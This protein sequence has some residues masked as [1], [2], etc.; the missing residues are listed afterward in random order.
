L[1]GEPIRLFKVAMDPSVYTPVPSF[2]ASG[3]AAPSP[4]EQTLRSGYIGQ[5]PRVDEFEAAL[6]DTFALPR[7]PV[8]VNSGTSALELALALIGVGPGDAVITTPQTCTATNS[9]IVT[10]GAI[11]VWAD[12]NARGL[13][14][15][16][17]VLRAWMLAKDRGLNVKAVMVV[18]WAGARP[19]IGRMRRQ[20]PDDLPIIED[21]AHRLPSGSVADYAAWSFQAIKFLTTGDGG[22]L[23][24]PAS[25][26]KRA[27]LLRWYGLDRD[28]AQDFRC[29]QNIAEVGHK[30]HMN[31]IAATI[32]LA[33]LR[34]AT[35]NLTAHRANASYLAKRLRREFDP[36]SHY[37]FFPY[38]HERRDALSAHLAA[39][40]IET[41]QV[42]ARND[43]HSGF[44]QFPVRLP[45][46][47]RFDATQLALP[48][49]W[50]L[51]RGDLDTIVEAIDAF[52][53]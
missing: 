50:W 37:W 16:E 49:G 9:P 33:N 32:G 7:L 24:T 5:G 42:H 46:V 51:D 25:Q 36:D 52:E 8:T 47:D 23:L 1:P 12:V 13:L 28:G 11:P 34:L 19:D 18:S 17:S 20:L 53:R 41:S 4:I 21:A 39:C 43:K 14:T 40:G 15:A 48:C 38:A 35:A 31:D 3:P 45:G 10:R 29:S 26:V 27:R 22:A 44:Q 6:K 30:W 2:S